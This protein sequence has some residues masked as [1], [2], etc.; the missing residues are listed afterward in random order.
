[1]NAIHW[2]YFGSLFVRFAAAQ[3]AWRR[4]CE[5]NAANKEAQA[6]LKR[7][8]ERMVEAETGK[9]DLARLVAEYRRGLLEMDVA[10]FHSPLVQVT[11]LAEDYK[12]VVATAPI[13]K[14]TL[15]VV[16]KAAAVVFDKQLD[17]SQNQRVFNHYKMRFDS[18]ANVANV[19][20][21]IQAMQGNP[22][23]ASQVYSLYPGKRSSSAKP[24]QPRSIRSF[25]I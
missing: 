18:D 11:E 4:C 9:V 7:A 14:A 25:S 21:L 5:V 20:K 8:G 13:P 24:C 10:D 15:L 16:S 23:L 22:D 2:I 3:D 12:G 6:A 19:S 1:M 17:K